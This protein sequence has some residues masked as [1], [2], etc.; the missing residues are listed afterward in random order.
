MHNRLRITIRRHIRL[1]LVL[2]MTT[3]ASLGSIGGVS[4]PSAAPATAARPAPTCAQFWRHSGHTERVRWYHC[5]ATSSPLTKRVHI[6]GDSGTLHGISV[7]SR[8]GGHWPR[9]NH[10]HDRGGEGC[11]PR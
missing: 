9:T 8:P 5:H 3:A 10:R 11:R 6:C 1:A 2:A 7:T 4:S